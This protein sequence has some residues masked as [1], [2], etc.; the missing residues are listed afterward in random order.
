[1]RCGEKQIRVVPQF[2]R[3]LPHICRI[4][5]TVDLGGTK[6]ACETWHKFAVSGSPSWQ[7]AIDTQGTGA[8]ADVDATTRSLLPPPFDHPVSLVGCRES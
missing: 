7:P 8:E 4:L 6:S 1:M 5:L 2:C 3:V